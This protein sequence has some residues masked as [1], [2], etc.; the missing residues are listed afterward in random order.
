MVGF[1]S[2]QP[3]GLSPSRSSIHSRN[4]FVDCFIF[5]LVFSQGSTNKLSFSLS[6]LFN[7]LIFSILSFSPF[8]SS[9]TK[10]MNPLLGRPL[11]LLVNSISCLTFLLGFHLFSPTCLHLLCTLATIFIFLCCSS[12][13]LVSCQLCLL[14]F[15]CSS[16]PLTHSY[17]G[18]RSLFY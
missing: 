9:F 11:F 12:N 7:F 8:I 17:T 15:N 6:K 1:L 5:W 4:N 2:G 18:T 14:H 10:L 3:N 13:I 16:N